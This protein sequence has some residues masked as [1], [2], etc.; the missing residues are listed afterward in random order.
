[1]QYDSSIN[2]LR[3]DIRLALTS[4][5]SGSELYKTLSSI[6]ITTG[7]VGASVDANTNQFQIDKNKL[8]EAMKT[9][10][11]SVKDLLVG[12]E[13]KGIKGIVQN[14]Q[15]IVDDALNTQNGFF[16]NRENTYTSQLNNL[17]ARIESKNNQLLSYQ[18]RLKLQFQNMETRIAKLQSQQSQMSSIFS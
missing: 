1:M 7:A 6:G 17:T 10:P 3:S 8:I 18:E 14:V 2:S 15:T 4:A 11:Q 5:A 12:N 9:D 16:T 13:E